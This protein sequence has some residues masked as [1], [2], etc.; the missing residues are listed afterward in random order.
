MNEIILTADDL[1]L[2]DEMNQLYTSKNGVNLTDNQVEF[3][4]LLGVKNRSQATTKKLKMLIKLYRQEKRFLAAKAKAQGMI[5][6]EKDAKRK[7]EQRLFYV[8]GEGILK[9]IKSD[10]E[11]EKEDRL[12]TGLRRSL[13][14]ACA[15]GIIEK[16]D[17]I[18][19]QKAFLSSVKATNNWLTYIQSSENI[20][21]TLTKSLIIFFGDNLARLGQPLSS[22]ELAEIYTHLEENSQPD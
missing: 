13:F 14:I 3:L 22:A 15:I 19:I 16:K 9:A 11:R 6:R 21:K 17:W 2:A 10:A 8:I 7:Q 18:V 4:R 1:N 12:F 5:K 20:D